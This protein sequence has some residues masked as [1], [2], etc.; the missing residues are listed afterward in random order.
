[1]I[2]RSYLEVLSAQDGRIFRTKQLGLDPERFTV[3]LA[4]GGNGANNHFA[5]LPALLKHADRIQAIIICG[6]NKETYNELIHWRA[7]HP[8]FNAYI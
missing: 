6:K 5:L 2:P 3:F 8:E 1:M 7:T 4:T